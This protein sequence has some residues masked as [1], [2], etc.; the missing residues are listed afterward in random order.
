MKKFKLGKRLK[1]LYDLVDCEDMI[2]Y[3][4]CCDHGHL[5]INVYLEKK[6][7]KVILNDQVQS[8]CENLE[9]TLGSH[10]TNGGISVF[11][12]SATQIKLDIEKRKFLV[13]AGVGGDLVIK[14]LENLIPQLNSDDFILVSPHSKIHKVRSFLIKNKFTSIGEKLIEE[15]NKFYEMLIVQKNDLKS[16]ISTIGDQIWLDDYSKSHTCLSE[17]IKYYKVKFKHNDDK[18]IKL[19]FSDLIAL[20]N[21]LN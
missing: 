2:F 1:A 5:G 9:N 11:C 21:K 17:Y 15:N 19:I 20:K 6:P 10:I 16:N 7:I 3:D 12:K 13:V 8:I 14:I 18:S 4:L